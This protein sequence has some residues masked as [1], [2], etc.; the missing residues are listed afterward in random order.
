M[1]RAGWERL[2]SG[3]RSAMVCAGPTTW[4]TG[5]R[6][7]VCT[8]PRRRTRP[9]VRTLSRSRGNPDRIHRT[10]DCP[11]DA[12]SASCPLRMASR[13]PDT[14]R[15]RVGACVGKGEGRGRARGSAGGRVVVSGDPA[16]T[17]VGITEELAAHAGAALDSRAPA[18]RIAE[19]S[20]PA[21]NRVG[22]GRYGRSARVG[23]A[24]TAAHRAAA[25]VGAT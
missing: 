17:H 8:V 23:L 21:R 4:K 16:R 12:N 11:P 19:R 18:R 14:P 2:G 5:G 10:P 15:G 22:G 7:N 24:E 9:P 3:R 13:R 25:S 6:A 1:T 20:R